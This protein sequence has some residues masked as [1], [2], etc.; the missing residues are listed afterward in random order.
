MSVCVRIKSLG[1][2][3]CRAPTTRR[4]R[5]ANL[6]ERIEAAMV[7]IPLE[8]RDEFKKLE[9][10]LNRMDEGTRSFWQTEARKNTTSLVRLVHVPA[11]ISHNEPVRILSEKPIVTAE[12]QMLHGI[13]ILYFDVKQS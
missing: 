7:E 3:G 12:W 9:T 10:I 2:D 1:G 13:M 11:S 5:L 4:D 6:K 8:M